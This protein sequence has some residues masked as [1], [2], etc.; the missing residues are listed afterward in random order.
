MR[1]ATRRIEGVVEPPEHLPAPAKRTH[2]RH[3]LQQY[4]TKRAWNIAQCLVSHFTEPGDSVLDPFCGSGV[5]PVEALALRRTALAC[6]IN[7]WAVFVT[8]TTAMAPVDLSFLEHCCRQLQADIRPALQRI[9]ESPSAL[10]RLLASADYPRDPIPQGIFQSGLRTLDQLFSRLQ[11]GELVLL[12]DAVRSVPVTDT[13]EL[14]RL[15]FSI[16][17]DRANRMYTAKGKSTALRGRSAPFAFKRYRVWEDFTYIP[18]D[19]LFDAAVRKV[20][21]AKAD[22]NRVLGDFVTDRTF[23][24]WTGSATRLGGHVPAETVDYVLTDPPYGRNYCY[25]DLSMIWNAWLDLDVPEVA[26]ADEIIIHGSRR[27]TQSDYR[28]LLSKAIA[29]M[30]RALKPGRW[31]T[32]VYSESKME[33]WSW[34][35]DTCRDQ[36]L[37]YVDSVWSESS[38]PTHKKTQSPYASAAGEFYIS[39]RKVGEQVY[40]SLYSRPL[41]QATAD[42]YDVVRLAAEKVI[43]A[44]LGARVEVIFSSIISPQLL[45]SGF[46]DSQPGGQLDIRD[47][48]SQHFD[49]NGGTWQ[50]RD[51]R[52]VDPGT[53]PYELLRYSLF[54]FLA[55]T[56]DPRGVRAEDI[57]NYLPRVLSLAAG[58]LPLERVRAV[59]HSFAVPVGHDRWRVDERKLHTFRQLRLFFEKSTTDRIRDSMPT[60]RPHRTCA[61]KSIDGIGIL[62]NRLLDHNPGMETDAVRLALLAE[63]VSAA[64]AS[65]LET[66]VAS[67]S[68]LDDFAAGS[69]NLKGLREGPLHLLVTL[70]PGEQVSSEQSFELSE[71]VLGPVLSEHRVWFQ[72]LLASSSE[73][74]AFADRKLDLV[75]A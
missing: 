41:P 36:E 57:R 18:T 55:R 65:E 47:V 56:S 22:A 46:L 34:L 51:P 44:Y 64:V 2:N 71:R 28:D 75:V 39:F 11:L 53:D 69:V 62:T 24:L 15:A 50:L 49:P 73:S 26:Y 17:L 45:G 61:R 43:V 16:T 25:L 38:L 7:P 42:P 37:R 54:H 66:A 72:P 31:L 4:F 59:L 74:A 35:L 33:N 1:Q 27:K 5:V 70:R 3:Y 60:S 10:N 21:T 48:L 67:V 6:D 63:H 52:S 58:A 20:L 13:R 12:R 8:R 29:E 19:E 9:R 23:H 68:A 32:L 14:L 40:R 30:A